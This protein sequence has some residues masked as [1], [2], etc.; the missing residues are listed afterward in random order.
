MNLRTLASFSLSVAN[1]SAALFVESRFATASSSESERVSFRYMLSVAFRYFPIVRWMYEL[2]A[3]PGSILLVVSH[4]K[5]ARHPMF[6][7]SL[8]LLGQTAVTTLCG[9]RRVKTGKVIVFLDADHATKILEA[10]ERRERKRQE[11]IE[12]QKGKMHRRA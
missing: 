2:L 7:N 1:R 12:E 6:R 4:G 8:V 9:V 10:A 5:L 3:Q 11:G